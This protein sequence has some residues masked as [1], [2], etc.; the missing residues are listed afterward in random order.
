MVAS[1]AER[2][3]R[4]D[5]S[6][7]AHADAAD[8][9]RELGRSAQAAA[10]DSAARAAHGAVDAD[11]QRRRNLDDSVRMARDIVGPE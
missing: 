7:A 5:I 1:E 3:Q 10:H 11:A 2:W 4:F 6:T 9:Y 8:I